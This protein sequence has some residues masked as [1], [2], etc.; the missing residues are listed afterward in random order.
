MKSSLIVLVPKYGMECVVDLSNLL[1]SGGGNLQF[2][3]ERIAFVKES[4]AEEVVYR[5]FQ[6]IKIQISVLEHEASLRERLI[7]KIADLN[8]NCDDDDDIKIN[9]ES[10][11][12]K[13]KL[14][15]ES[16]S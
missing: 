4:N 2:D 11:S 12:P 9:L 13:R 10:S 5:L 1:L 16:E 6:H 7:V 8:L 15:P 3:P 14:Q